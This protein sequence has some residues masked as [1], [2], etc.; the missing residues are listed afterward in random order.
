MHLNP[1]KSAFVLGTTGSGCKAWVQQRVQKVGGKQMINF[2]TA[3]EPLCIP[4]ERNSNY[5]GVIVSYG[6]F[7]D[8]TFRHRLQVAHQDFAL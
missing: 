4:I 6:K 7:E 1:Q 8:A 5:L 3:H 2:G